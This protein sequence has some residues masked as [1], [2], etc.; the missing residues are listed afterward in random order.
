MST[1]TRRVLEVL[2]EDPARERF[3]LEVGQAAGLASGTV[4]P[5]LARLEGSGWLQSRWED[6]EPRRGGPPPRRFYLLTG[7]GAVRARSALTTPQH[8]STAI[9]RLRPAGGAT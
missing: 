9:G 3:G 7:T 8:T 4:H 1:A 6:I 2:L 5:I